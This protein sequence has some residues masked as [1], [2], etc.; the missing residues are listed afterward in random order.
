MA[1]LPFAHWNADVIR[2]EHLLRV[3]F[4]SLIIAEYKPEV[5]ESS[6]FSLKQRAG[7][8]HRYGAC[9][10]MSSRRNP[11]LCWSA[12]SF[13]FVWSKI[14]FRSILVCESSDWKHVPQ[15]F[16]GLAWLQ[17]NILGAKSLDFWIYQA[18]KTVSSSW[19]LENMH[20]YTE[21]RFAVRSAYCCILYFT[22][23][24]VCLL[25]KG[26]HTA[27]KTYTHIYKNIS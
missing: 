18:A 24:G 6:V 12:M 4:E 19:A 14:Y 15:F 10:G 25:Y 7:D 26:L 9:S 20:H 3:G 21:L 1:A 13:A 16:F 11:L 17:N 22:Q 23:E 27:I 5:K 2:A 8:S